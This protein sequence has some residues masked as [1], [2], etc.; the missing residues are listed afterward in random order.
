VELYNVVYHGLA[1]N[2]IKLDG[3]F[4][5]VEEAQNFLLSHTQAVIIKPE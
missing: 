2:T 3:C 4:Q 5:Q 1:R